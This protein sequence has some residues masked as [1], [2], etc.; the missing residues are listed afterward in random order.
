[1][2][3]SY[4]KYKL[5]INE[6]E[7]REITLDES[8]ERYWHL[9]TEDA[10]KKWVDVYCAL[11]LMARYGEIPC[12]LN[13][14][15]YKGIEAIS[16]KELHRVSWCLPKKYIS[17]LLNK[18]FGHYNY[19]LSDYFQWDLDL[20]QIDDLCAMHNQYEST[21]KL[22]LSEK[23]FPNLVEKQSL[24]EEDESFDDVIIDAPLEV[25]SVTRST[26]KTILFE[27]DWN[28]LNDLGIKV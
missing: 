6:G 14:P 15:D 2:S 24:I 26:A 17:S 19:V 3:N 21:I 11:V 9:R 12:S 8:R 27:L 4:L 7:N 28:E 10:S 23:N 1:M 16:K 25:V 13:L 18:V 5:A 22:D 20:S